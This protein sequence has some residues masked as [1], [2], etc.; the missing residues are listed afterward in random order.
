MSKAWMSLWFLDMAYQHAKQFDKD[1]WFYYD[2][3][4][5]WFIEPEELEEE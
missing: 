4:L 1:V 5:T 2:N 3:H